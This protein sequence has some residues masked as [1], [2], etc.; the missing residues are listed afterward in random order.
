VAIVAYLGGI[1]TGKTYNMSRDTVRRARRRRAKLVANYRIRPGDGVEFEQLTMGHDGI[2]VDRLTAI[3]DEALAC[4]TCA[5]LDVFGDPIHGGADCQ[6]Y[7]LEVVIDE[8]GIL[9]PARFWQDFP[10]D[11]FYQ[12]SQSRKQGANFTYSA[13]AAAQVDKQLRDLTT[14]AWLCKVFPGAG[15]AIERTEQGRRPWLFMLA[16][17]KLLR[18]ENGEPA[19]VK[20]LARSWRRYDRSM[21]GVYSTF[22]TIKTPAKFRDAQRDRRDAKAAKRAARADAAA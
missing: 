19:R 1:G 3:V 9:M 16:K 20:P 11:L 22:E 21:E 4:S 7:G 12:L 14:Y 2:D 17:H 15:D 18:L 5:V 10:I 6:R 13:Q 8:V